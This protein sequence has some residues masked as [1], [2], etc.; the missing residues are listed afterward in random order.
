MLVDTHAHL[1]FP[2]LAHELPSVMSRAAQ[3]GVRE[4][5]TIGISVDSSQRAVDLAKAHERIYATVGVHPHGAFDLDQET[6]DGLIALAGHT[7]VVAIGE[8]GLD[9][10]R[11]RQPRELQKRCMCQQ[12]EIAQQMD[13]PVVF[14]IREAY[15]DFLEII[16]EYIG[17]LRGVVLH[18]FSGDWKVAKQCL[19]LGCYLSVPGTVTF[20]RAEIQQE[21]VKLAPPERLLLETDAPF[22]APAPYRGKVNEPS[23]ILYTAHKVAELLNWPIEEVGAQAT[24]NAHKVFKMKCRD[25]AAR[26]DG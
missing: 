13:L 12:L 3:N 17:N 7:K 9:Y 20:P 15:S 16:E 22:L 4:I 2:E 8:I 5:V 18:C 19:H 1:D 25:G 10:Y 21:V 6:R 11:D 26:D 14:H 23:Y 24:Q